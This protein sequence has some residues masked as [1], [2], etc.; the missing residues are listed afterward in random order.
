M[1]IE[2]FADDSKEAI[3][4][5]Y[6]QSLIKGN[7]EVLKNDIEPSLEAKLTDEILEQMRALLGSEEPNE[8]NLIGY[9]AHTYNQE[10]TRYNL[11]Y[12]YA[13][14]EQWIVWNVAFRT[15]PDGSNEI[16]GLNVYNPMDRSLQ[17]IHR[18]ELLGKSI[19]HYAFLML[20][21]LIPIF[22]VFTLIIAIRTKFKKRKWIW[23]LFIVFGCG[24]FSLDWTSGQTAFQLLS[25]QFL[26]VGATS[27][28]IY[29]PWIL[30]FGPPIGALMFWIK[31]K[32][33]T[34]MKVHPAGVSN[35]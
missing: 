17:D 20:C 12:Q 26:G 5:V 4:D 25:F 28:S 6:I 31:R 9:T 10:P 13:Y 18:F 35:G 33:L 34:K 14:D 2:E 23:I 11:T 24:T 27:A 7:F 15:L 16:F 3:A 21:L 19:I 30:S 1:A 22:I 8:K 32:Q 29:A